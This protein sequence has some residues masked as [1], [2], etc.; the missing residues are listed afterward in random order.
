[1][2]RV[3]IAY[4][5]SSPA[6]A[7]IDDLCNAGLPA[8]LEATVMC[9]ADVWMPPELPS[10]SSTS[11]PLFPEAVRKARVRASQAV[12]E[13]WVVAE[14][15]SDRVRELFPKWQ[16]TPLACGDSPSWA[17][18]QKARDWSADLVV[19]GAHSHPALERLFLGSVAQRAMAEAHCS[20]RIARP[21]GKPRR[22]ELGIMVAVDG[23]SD[24]ENAVREVARRR[25]PADASFSLV[26]VIDVRM[27]SL[28]AWPGLYADRPSQKPFQDAGDWISQLV[29]HLGSELRRGGR[30]VETHI[31]EGDPKKVLVK[32]AAKWRADCLF[33]GAHGLQHGRHLFLG[34]LATAV[35]TRAPCSVEIVRASTKGS[36]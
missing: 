3:L 21:C 2:K 17:V 10:G 9:V 27:Q 4:D 30:A 6:E 25:W 29:E 26:S 32:Q 34:S 31:L 5:G 33:V 1:M 19:V 36:P 23:S 20:V 7:A 12:S 16:V 8:Q 24:S 35:A 18:V 28:L 14:R 13:A 15:G 11:S 22:K